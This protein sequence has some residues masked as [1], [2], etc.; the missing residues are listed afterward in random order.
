MLIEYQT[1]D[2]TVPEE[3]KVGV[4]KVYQKLEDMNEFSHCCSR[5]T[6]FYYNYN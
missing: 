1:K 4:G 5:T 2:D 6:K 3:S